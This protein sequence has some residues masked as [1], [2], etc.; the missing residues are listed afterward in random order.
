MK[1]NNAPKP[2][3]EN[4]TN[5]VY[6]FECTVGTCRGRK[7]DYIGLTTTS[8]KKRMEN[9]RY[10][11]AIHMHFKQ[12]HDRRPKTG[13]LLE[14]SKVL[15]RVDNYHRLA[16]TEA[17]SIELQKPLLNIQREFDL[18]LPSCRRRKRENNTIQADPT[19]P[20]ST[21]TS[22]G[23]PLSCTSEGSQRGNV[24]RGEPGS[25]QRTEEP[26]QATDYVRLR[27]RPRARAGETGRMQVQTRTRRGTHYQGNE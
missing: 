3:P 2:L 19:S 1:N 10:N 9:H 7:I 22:P 18:V 4:E 26:I 14:N 5:I 15:H 20:S 11:G 6:K 12:A 27:L 8:L 23:A 25:E 24:A 13:E 17:V 21:P 16:I